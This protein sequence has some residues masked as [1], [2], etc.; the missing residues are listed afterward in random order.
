MSSPDLH[1]MTLLAEGTD[2]ATALR[3][4]LE[5]RVWPPR[6]VMFRT[7]RSAIRM[8]NAGR[9]LAECR[10][11]EGVTYGT[12]GRKTA[13]AIQVIEHLNLGCFLDGDE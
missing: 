1:T 11:P 12:H 5:A 9:P 10:L 4:H 13:P 3:F 6:P 8:M 2:Q 7:A